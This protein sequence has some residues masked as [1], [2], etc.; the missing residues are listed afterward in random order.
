MTDDDDDSA[1]GENHE[2]MTDPRDGAHGPGRWISLGGKLRWHAYRS[3]AGPPVDEA[4]E[5]DASSDA[6]ALPPVGD[7]VWEH[8]QPPIP[9]GAPERLRVRAALTWLDHQQERS[10]DQLLAISLREHEALLEQ[11]S[12]VQPHRRRNQP[13][14]PLTLER[15]ECEGISAWF[16]DAALDL[17]EAV[18]RTPGRALVEWYLS[19]MMPD[20]SVPSPDDPLAAA[21]REGRE[22]AR[23]R[24]LR[25]AERVAQP[26]VDDD[27]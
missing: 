3:I 11:E 15:S 9:P 13:P 14:N 5:D 17:R 8:D 21:R 10:R 18:D 12:S 16:E 22:H 24:A 2:R 7:A 6:D 1:G 20:D 25:Y 19:L 23:E 26:E 27:L 4:D